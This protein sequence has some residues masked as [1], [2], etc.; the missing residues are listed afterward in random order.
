MELS[1]LLAFAGVAAMLAFVPGPDWAF[2]VA[3]SVRE[4]AVIPAVTGVA[5]GYG[6]LTVVVAVGVGPLVASEPAALAVITIAGAAYLFY[7]GVS[8]LRSSRHHPQPVL[9]AVPD[10]APSGDRQLVRRGIG[11]S[12]LNPKGLLFFVAFL[13]QFARPASSWPFSVQLIVLGAVYVVINA[14]FYGALGFTADRTIA[15]RPRLAGLITR[16]AG[17]GMIVVSLILLSQ[18]ILHSLSH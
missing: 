10:A 12:A 2:I 6:V 13:P 17:V 16:V 8:I 3:A 7:L 5:A 4:R 14:I 1:A 15:G 9:S 11:V 18:Q